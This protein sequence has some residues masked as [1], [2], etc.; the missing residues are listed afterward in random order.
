M[1]VGRDRICSKKEELERKTLK[2]PSRREGMKENEGREGSNDGGRKV[3][4]FEREKRGGRDGEKERDED[5]G[6]TS[7]GG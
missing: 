4:W 2:G 3:L 6:W 5:E 1:R 7:G